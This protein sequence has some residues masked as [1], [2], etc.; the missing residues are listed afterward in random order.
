MSTFRTAAFHTLAVRLGPKWDNLPGGARFE[1]HRL[2]QVS[3]LQGLNQLG[4]DPRG[5]AP[6]CPGLSRCTPLGLAL[7]ASKPGKTSS[8][9]PTKRWL[10]G[11]SKSSLMRGWPPDGGHGRGEC[12]GGRDVFWHKVGK[13]CQDFLVTHPGG[14]LPQNIIDR[15]D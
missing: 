14:Q 3:P 2:N 5:G 12:Q 13:V 10:R 4:A 15:D 6:L 11:C 7:L 9:S 1:P 8:N